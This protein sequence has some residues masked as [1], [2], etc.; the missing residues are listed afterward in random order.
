MAIDLY[1]ILV[2]GVEARLFGYE[3]GLDESDNKA[4]E[5]KS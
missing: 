4:T 3:Q 2:I 1:L 5:K